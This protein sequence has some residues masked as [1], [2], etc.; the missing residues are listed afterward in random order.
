MSRGENNRRMPSK[1][2]SKT[3]LTREIYGICMADSEYYVP[4]YVRSTVEIAKQPET[5]SAM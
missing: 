3:K 2:T 1:A 5:Y 4:L